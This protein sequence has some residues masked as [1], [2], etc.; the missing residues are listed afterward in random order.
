MTDRTA[1]AVTHA[2]RSLYATT[3]AFSPVQVE[4]IKAFVRWLSEEPSR[5]FYLAGYAGTGKTTMAGWLIG[6]LGGMGLRLPVGAFTGKAAAVLRRKGL[7]QAG[8]IHSQIYTPIEGSNPVRFELTDDSPFATADL[9]TIDEVSMLGEDLAADV[10]S[11]GRKI[12]VLGD[13]GQLPPINGAGAFTNRKPDVFLTEI[14]RQAAESPILR[15]ATRARLGNV[16]EWSD[17]P[18]ARVTK[19]TWSE[20]DQAK[21]Q[22]ICGTHRARWAITE[23]VR[24]NFNFDG[25]WPM[26]GERVICRRNDRDSGLYNGMLGVVEEDLGLEDELGG[27]TLGDEESVY[28][29]YRVRMD[30][31]RS[32]VEV[33][34]DPTPF[35]EH[36]VKARLPTQRYQR[37]VQLFDFGYVLTCHSAQGSEWPEVTIVDDSTA[38]RED[39]WRWLYTAVTRASESVTVLRRF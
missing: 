4:A 24:K 12:L 3:G 27:V 36:R 14:H 7:S 32:P 37:G 17:D 5:E 30:D 19:L 11:F 22:L 39:R 28:R 38:F 2:V 23:R 29:R 9:I 1:E 25:M 34:V 21:G 16:P 8:T 33:L 20:V 13:P 18:A 15:L 26:T 6:H 10:R 31:L 35:S